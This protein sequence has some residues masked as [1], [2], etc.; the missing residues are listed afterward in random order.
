MTGE[1]DK[2]TTLLV[3]HLTG[4]GCKASCSFPR[5]PT[6]WFV[7]LVHTLIWSLVSG[8]QG[9]FCLGHFTLESLSGL[10]KRLGIAASIGILDRG[11]ISGT[12]RIR[13][14]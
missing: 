4:R 9:S 14:P 3:V 5:L 1:D 11:A 8:Q 7:Y 2:S 6:T 10:P 12:D 13:V